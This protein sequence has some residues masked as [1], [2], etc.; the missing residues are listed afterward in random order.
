MNNQIK[1]IEKLLQSES[2]ELILDIATGRGEFIKLLQNTLKKYGKIIGIDNSAPLLELNR[3]N[4]SD[5]RIEFILM[6]ALKLDFDDGYFDMVTISNSLHHFP[7]PSLLLREALR[8]LRKGGLLLINEMVS[9]PGQSEAQ[10]SHIMI[11]HWCSHIDRCRGIYHDCTYTKQELSAIMAGLPTES[12]IAYDYTYP[13]ADPRNEPMIQAYSGLIDP[14]VEKIK[15]HIEYDRLKG[16]AEEIKLHLQ[17]QGY[18][19]ADS[20]FFVLKK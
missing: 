4:F 8:V 19:P 3:K 9:D 13:L 1:D 10:Q 5:H 7:Q 15:G 12:R 20:I 14:Y 11:H 2:A 18:A 17:E 6:D 16:E